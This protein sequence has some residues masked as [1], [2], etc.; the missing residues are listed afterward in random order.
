MNILKKANEIKKQKIQRI[1]KISV[2]SFYQS[3]VYL[4]W[5]RVLKLSAHKAMNDFCSTES[6]FALKVWLFLKSLVY[7][8]HFTVVLNKKINFLNFVNFLIFFHFLVLFVRQELRKKIIC[9]S[10]TGCQKTILTRETAKK[11]K[12]KKKKFIFFSQ[13]ICTILLFFLFGFY[14]LRLFEMI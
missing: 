4:D 1:A 2:W 3:Y 14:T 13:H 7:N 11:L 10:L 5:P 8:T 6:M 12:K 9:F